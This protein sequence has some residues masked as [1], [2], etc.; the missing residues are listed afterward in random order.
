MVGP[1]G[2]S[3]QQPRAR[4]AAEQRGGGAHLVTVRLR[5]SVGVRE[6]AKRYGVRGRDR[7]RVKLRVIGLCAHEGLEVAHAKCHLVRVRGL[8]D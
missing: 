1:C 3:E 5:L 8:T 2:A 4:G 6:R 7:G